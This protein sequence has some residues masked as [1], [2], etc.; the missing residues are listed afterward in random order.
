[1]DL[2]GAGPSWPAQDVWQLGVRWWLVPGIVAMERLL[3]MARADIPSDQR[4]SWKK[5]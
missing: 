3:Q 5:E 4:T 1:V 2:N